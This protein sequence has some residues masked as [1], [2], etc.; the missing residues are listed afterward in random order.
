MFKSFLT[1]LKPHNPALIESIETAYS[2]CF[3][4]SIVAY[5]GTSNDFDEFSEYRPNFF[6]TN[7]E[8][9]LMYEKGNGNKKIINLSY[10]KLLSK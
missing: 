10:Y 8:Y 2:V 3:E 4:N 7:R 6:T 5:H 1:T 9:A